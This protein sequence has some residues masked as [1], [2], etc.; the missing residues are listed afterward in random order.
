MLAIQEFGQ[1]FG[2]QLLSGGIEEDEFAALIFLSP[3]AFCLKQEGRF[4]FY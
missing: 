4:I 1:L 2:R 3:L